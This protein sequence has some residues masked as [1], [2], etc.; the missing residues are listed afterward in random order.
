[1]HACSHTKTLCM[2]LAC[3]PTA[4]LLCCCLCIHVRGHLSNACHTYH[5]P[6]YH[7]YTVKRG[8]SHDRPDRISLCCGNLTAPSL[9]HPLKAYKNVQVLWSHALHSTPCA[10]VCMWLCLGV[11][12]MQAAAQRTPGP[13]DKPLLGVRE[14]SLGGDNFSECPTGHADIIAYVDKQEVSVPGGGN[15]RRSKHSHTMKLSSAAAARAVHG[16]LKH[17]FSWRAGAGGKTIVE[18]HVRVR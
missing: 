7:S 10:C 6:S 15:L 9:L 11:C 14:V 16:K 1:M 8:A 17:A 5:T 3:L 4:I 13:R 2:M 18:L 12:H